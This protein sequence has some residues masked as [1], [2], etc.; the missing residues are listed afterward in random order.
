M[1]NLLDSSLYYF[2][3]VAQSGSLSAATEKLGATVSALSRHIAKL[4]GDVGA[5]LF[6]RHARGMVLSDAGRML[7][8]YA[9]SS[10][11]EGQAVMSAIQGDKARRE[12]KLRISCTEGFAL[13]FL[14]NSLSAFYTQHRDAV[15]SIEVTSSDGASRMLVDGDA[16]IALSF[17][18]KPEPDVVAHLTLPAPVLALMSQDHPLASRQTLSLVDLQAH[19]V[20]LQD[21]GTTIRQL[22]DIACNVE[23]IDVVTPITSRYVASLYRFTQVIPGAIMLSGFMSVANRFEAD[24]LVAVPFDNP[25]LQQRR[26]QVK[27]SAARPLTELATLCLEHLTADLQRTQARHP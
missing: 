1:R 18:L 3:V 2:S 23:G 17:S 14:P 10:L 25:L 22:F 26:L 9:Q 19:P 16:A 21:T 11:A 15:I 12:R 8:R 24:G 20:L 4:E 13:D 5:P 7:L 6:E 27:T